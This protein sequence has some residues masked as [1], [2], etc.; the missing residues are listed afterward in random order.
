MW[1]DFWNLW[2]FWLGLMTGFASLVLGVIGLINELGS[3][4]LQ[5]WI[6]AFVCL[7]VG[8]CL[9]QAE[10]RRK[11]KDL[12][13]RLEGLKPKLRIHTVAERTRDRIRIKVSNLSDLTV[14][15]MPDLRTLI[16]QLSIRSEHFF[17]SQD[18]RRPIENRTFL[19]KRMR[20][21]TCL[22][23]RKSG[24]MPLARLKT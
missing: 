22:W 12:E 17:K 15:F 3:P 2:R 9:L 23:S 21:W 7:V 24:R 16:H 4:A 1:R 6:P 5:F 14:R 18:L 13:K 19:A 8:A 10:T 20:M 11:F